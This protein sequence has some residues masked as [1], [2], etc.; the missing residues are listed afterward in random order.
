M[1]EALFFCFGS[2]GGGKKKEGGDVDKIPKETERE[3]SRRVT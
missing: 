1:Y 2:V 3:H